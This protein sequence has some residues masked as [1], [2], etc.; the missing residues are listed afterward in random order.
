MKK[1]FFIFTVLLSITFSK[2]A[3]KGKL[4]EV[5]T[6]GVL[7]P[8]LLQCNNK[9][10]P[11]GINT[12]RPYLSWQLQSYDRGSFQSA[13]Q[14]CVANSEEK[15]NKGEFDLWDSGKIISAKTLE[16]VYNGLAMKSA[17]IC[18]W[19]VRVWDENGGVS[20]WSES[21][22]WEMGLLSTSDWTGS[23]IS[24]GK[25]QPQKDE[26][27]YKND[28][29]PLFRKKFTV[30]KEI[31]K[32]RLYITGLGYYEAFI[33]G[34][35]V[36]DRWFDPG[37]TTYSKRI[38]YSCYDI[39]DMLNE[40]N[41]VLGVILGNG[42]FNPLPMKM[43]GRYNFREHLAIGRPRFI[44]TLTIDYEDSTKEI[45]VTDKSWKVDEGPILRNNVYLGEIYDAR[46][47][48]K[49]WNL[50]GFDDLKWKN[51]HEV[52]ADKSILHAQEQPPI[53]ITR[54]ITPVKISE[55]KPA[56]YIIDLGQNFAGSVRLKVKG[57]RGTKIR[58]RY[59][60][61]L[62]PDGTLNPMTSVAGQIKKAG[63]GGSGAPDTAWQ[64]DVY[65][66]NGNGKEIYIPRFGFRGFRYVEL[67]GFPERPGFEAITGLLMNSDVDSSGSF[68]CSNTMFNRIYEITRWTFLSNLF[69]VQSDCPHREKF[70]YGG[71]IV[72]SSEA[73]MF[74]FDM[75]SFYQKVI[76]D[77]ADAGRPNGGL[78]ETAPF[79]GISYGNFGEMSGP[80]GWG[81]AFPLLLKQ[82]YQ[83]YGVTHTLHE[84]YD[85][86]KNWFNLIKTHAV[87]F[88]VEEGIS[89]HESL[90]EKPTSLTGTAFFYETARLLSWQANMLG[91][92]EEEQ[93]YANFA[94]DIKRAFIAKFLTPGTGKFDK[95]TQAS[96]VFALYFGLVPDEMKQ[97][98]AHV[99]YNEVLISHKG[100]LAT[101]IFGT[102]YM[103]DVLSET[104]RPDIAYN[105]VNKK[106]FPGWGFMLENDATTLWEHWE[107]SDN[108]FSHNHPMF[109]SVIEWFI[110]TIAGI[111][112]AD[113]AVGFNKIIINPEMIDGL[114]WAK[115]TYNSV[116]GKIISDWEIKNNIFT[117]S[118]EIPVNTTAMVWL[119][120][121]EL[122]K[123]KENTKEINKISDLKF[124]KHSGGKTVLKI[125]SG[126]YHF[127]VQL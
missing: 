17:G 81:F 38:L 12:P 56:T 119:P 36:G 11:L 97:A 98:A 28:P 115:A 54:E 105:I 42:W 26:D 126:K 111:S 67:T 14:I 89:D 57:K 92:E 100:H 39:T 103:L 43:W 19:K 8:T 108:T 41:N 99:L 31:K 4:G 46:L 90:D 65:I 87:N 71:D 18:F 86:A 96:Q 82:L 80:I 116:R 79:V 50:A 95:H 94:K 101:G 30:K 118:V 91:L 58:M 123:I 52:E 32:A 37:W 120:T 102:K 109:G 29:A 113:D 60:E 93:E 110:K 106:T 59:G 74:D 66:L 69:S 55:P 83:Y 104:G 9:I 22:R 107:F 53:R 2:A 35:R 6:F 121:N 23:W 7:T 45:I 114:T 49:E 72:A 3:D 1:L 88:I 40:E 25:I 122:L 13:Y 124:I 78:T 21:A 68:S 85:A 127:S 112:P 63:M 77:F 15:L 61:L 117:L 62:Y 73:L 48:Q 34:K 44:A 47:Q 51:V 75:N 64:A 5:D 16:R 20:L 10:N 70:G 27:F 33:N 24:D 76:R 125:G 84:Q